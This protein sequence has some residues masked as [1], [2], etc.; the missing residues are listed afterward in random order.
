M[1]RTSVRRTGTVAWA[2]QLPHQPHLDQFVAIGSVAGALDANFSAQAELE[3]FSLGGNSLT[4][5]GGVPSPARFNRLAW[6]SVASPATPY[7]VLAAGLENGEI[8]LYNPHAVAHGSAA[9][10]A[11]PASADSA[12]A[13]DASALFRSPAHSAAVRGLDFNP[14]QPHLLGTGAGEGEILIWDLH[15]PATPYSPGATKTPRVAGAEITALAWNRCVPHI[16]ATSSSNG[17]TVVWDLKNRREVFALNAPTSGS[18]GGAGMWN[19]GGAAGMSGGGARRQGVVLAWHPDVPTQFITALED[20]ANPAIYMWDLRNAHAP[21]KVLSGHTKGIMS[22]AWCPKDSDLLLSCGKDNRTLCWNPTE[23]ELLGELPHADN[24]CFDVQWCTRNP[25]LLSIASFDGSVTVQSLMPSETAAPT[26]PLM[27]PSDP[28]AL[29]TPSHGSTTTDAHSAIS[30][31]KPPKWLRRPVSVAFGWGNRIVTVASP[32]PAALPNAGTAAGQ[33]PATPLPAPPK[34]VVLRRHVSPVARA[35]EELQTALTKNGVADL[36]RERATATASDADAIKKTS[37]LVLRALLDGD[38]G[39]KQLVDLL[40]QSV[41]ADPPSLAALKLDDETIPAAGVNATADRKLVAAIVRGDYA[42]AVGIAVAAGNYADALLLAACG[43]NDLFVSTR[44]NYLKQ[45]TSISHTLLFRVT[46]GDWSAIVSDRTLDWRQVLVTLLTYV[47]GEEIAEHVG[48]L[49]DRISEDVASGSSVTGA[50]I[51]TIVCHALAGNIEKLVEIWTARLHHDAQDTAGPWAS[52]VH[53]RLARVHAVV[54]QTAVLTHALHGSDLAGT[55]AAGQL[56]RVYAEYAIYIA[57][58]GALSAAWKYAQKLHDNDWQTLAGVKDRIYSG[59]PQNQDA[60][61]PKPFDVVPVTNVVEQEAAAAAAAKAAAA[62]AA[63]AMAPKP[64][65]HVPQISTAPAPYGGGYKPYQ[66]APVAPAPY[67]QPQPG[68]PAPYNPYAAAGNPYGQAAPMAGGNPYAPTV[69]APQP[70]PYMGAPVATPSSVPPP[71]SGPATS[72]PTR[73]GTG[74]NDAPPMAA[75]PVVPR[76]V[77][78]PAPKPPTPANAGGAGGY[79]PYGAPSAGYNPYGP[80]PSAGGAAAPLPP[81]TASAVPAPPPP[82][83]SGAPIPPPPSMMMAAPNATNYNYGAGGAAPAPPAGGYGAPPA[84]NAPPSSYA[85][86]PLAAHGMAPPQGPQFARPPSMPTPAPAPPAPAPAPAP[87]VPVGHPAGDRSHIAPENQPL[88]TSLM[89]A[90]QTIRAIAGAQP[91]QRR[92]VDDADKRLNQLLDALNNN[93]VAPNVLASLRVFAQAI[94]A[95]D[96]T[97]AIR[98]QQELAVSAI[99]SSMTLVLKRL[100]DVLARA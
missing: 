89:N 28:F 20:D 65:P 91:A 5:L 46:Q 7:G 31:K 62:A 32:P 52:K 75:I 67:G 2:P 43:D 12:P 34:V 92:L 76:A 49:G 95:R 99:D 10:D 27:T 78:P 100:V 54:E 33:A 82:A 56:A 39:R 40:E 90:Q 37:W 83:A 59:L 88:A 23:G 55:P 36:V 13:E 4:R 38:A 93:A 19:A 97:T 79:Q 30:L 60:P 72:P 53:D 71:P 80:G 87:A 81:A 68:A 9:A 8:A 85:P 24:W 70:S 57:H 50:E 66:P 42:T 14:I 45:R 11:A 16:L 17:V 41:S 96:W 74:W 64:S 48:K 86:Q 69:A 26:S 3:I 77:Q 63:A 15:N 61:P 51:G 25:D 1:T 29:I 94:D 58:Q 18:Q 98:V 84:G 21:L 35:A 6:S 47:Q 44:D 22:V 73:P